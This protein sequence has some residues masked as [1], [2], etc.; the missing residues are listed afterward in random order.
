MIHLFLFRTFKLHTSAYSS[1][2][3]E[4]FIEWDFIKIHFLLV[5]KWHQILF[6]G[7]VAPQRHEIVTLDRIFLWW[8]NAWYQIWFLSRQLI[9]FEMSR[10]FMPSNRSNFSEKKTVFGTKRFLML[11]KNTLFGQFTLHFRRSTSITDLWSPCPNKKS[12]HSFWKW[13]TVR[14]HND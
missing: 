9:S 10:Y 5:L 2:Y 6:K 7:E 14:P 8:P 13:N 11:W 3:C 4:Y 1:N 12:T